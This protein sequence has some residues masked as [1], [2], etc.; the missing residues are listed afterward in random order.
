MG[1]KVEAAASFVAAGGERAVICALDEA[2]EALQGG[3]GS[4]I[5]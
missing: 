4:T 2:P 5:A 1:P 3:A